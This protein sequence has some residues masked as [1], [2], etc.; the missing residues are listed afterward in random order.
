MKDFNWKGIYAKTMGS[1]IVINKIPY[2]LSMD[3][4][5]DCGIAEQMKANSI[6]LR[7]NSVQDLFKGYEYSSEFFEKQ[8]IKKGADISS[9]R[10]SDATISIR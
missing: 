8:N 1:P 6:L 3:E 2:P 4:D 10:T 5:V 9:N 7:R